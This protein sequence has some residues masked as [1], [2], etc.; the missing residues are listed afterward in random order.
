[1][2]KVSAVLT[3]KDNGYLKESLDSIKKQKIDDIEIICIGDGEISDVKQAND[4][5]EA[6]DM[7]QG[8]YVYFSATG[9]ILRDDT[10]KNCIRLMEEK[11]L[12]FV[13]YDAD[14]DFDDEVYRFNTL[15]GKT[16]KMDMSLA[17][18]F[19][20]TSFIKKID[21]TPK[22]DYVFFWKA[23]FKAKSFA[24]YRTSIERKTPLSYEEQLELIE[25][26]NKVYTLFSDNNY[27]IDYKF[28]YFDWRI[29]TLYK[30]YTEVDEDRKEDYYNALKDDF[31]RMLYHRRFALF[32][33]DVKPINKLFFN[34]IVFSKD[35]DDFNYLLVQYELELENE[36]IKKEIEIIKKN[37]NILKDENNKILNSTSW[38]ITKPLRSL[39][40]G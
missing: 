31:S 13:Q 32:S 39:K 34:D 28:I 12:D 1:M 27:F 38:K 40:N 36:E 11:N 19:F 33:Y 23:I 22:D 21:G 3:I 20:R 5:A 8:E 2:V 37:I 14:D 16:F 18:K 15:R 35:F 25:T 24:F 26:T 10:F 29:E 30:A 6:L 4:M 17:T 9:D 7:I